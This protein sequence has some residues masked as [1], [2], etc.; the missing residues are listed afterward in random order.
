M[1]WPVGRTPSTTIFGAVFHASKGPAEAFRPIRD[2]SRP[3]SSPRITPSTPIIA[4]TTR[5]P[6]TTLTR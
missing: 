1:T 2:Y 5:N 4:F 3:A 6:T